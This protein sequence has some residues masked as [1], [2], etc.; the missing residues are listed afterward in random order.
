MGKIVNIDKGD[1][2]TAFIQTFVETGDC[3]KAALEAGF[4]HGTYGYHLRDKLADKIRE[5]LNKRIAAVAPMALTTLANLAESA[6]SEAVKRQAAKD[7]MGF[8]GFDIRRVED[9]TRTDIAER[10]NKARTR[11]T[12][13]ERQ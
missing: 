13:L 11:L 12:N 8:A 7:V 3:Q 10:L 2:E 9:V 5:A 4:S 1:K 6:E